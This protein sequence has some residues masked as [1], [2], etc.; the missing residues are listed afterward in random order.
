MIK[1]KIYDI[2]L[3]MIYNSKDKPNSK[4]KE[5]KN[6]KKTKI[7]YPFRLKKKKK[8]KKPF[9]GPSAILYFDSINFILLFKNNNK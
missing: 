3:M 2:L 6:Q 9:L 1:F 8:K 5:K 4:I 7:R